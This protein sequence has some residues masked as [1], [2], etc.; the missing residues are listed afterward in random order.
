M[1][2]RILEAMDQPELAPRL[3][4]LT[5]D[6]LC[7]SLT[8]QMPVLAALRRP[9]R[10]RR[11]CPAALPRGRGTRAAASCRRSRARCS[12]TSTTTSA[13]RPI[14]SPR[15]SPSATSGCARPVPRH[16]REALEASF[17]LERARILA[18]ARELHPDASVEMADH[19]LTKEAN[20]EKN[21]RP[22][23]PSS[24]PSPDCARRS[25]SLQ[26]MP[27]ER[28]TDYQWEVLEAILQLLPYAAAH[29]KV[30]FGERGEADFT[31][32]AQGA[33]ARARHAAR[34]PTDLLLA[35][36]Y[37]IKHILVDEFQDT[38][39]S[40]WELL[41]LLTSGWTGDDGRTLFLVGDPMQS[42]YRFREAQV[43]LFLQARERGLGQREARAAHAHHQF[44]LAGR[45]S[46]TSS[47]RLSRESCPPRPTRPP[48]RFPTPARAAPEATRAARRG[49]DL[50]RAAGPRSRGAPCGASSCARPKDRRRDPRAQ[51]RRAR[52]HRARAQGRAASGFAPSRS[53]SSARSRWCRTSTP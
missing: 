23:P 2:K 24:S 39:I 21:A 25:I 34:H 31:E 8:R 28:Y 41:S 46:S 17:A 48:A 49:R 3:R 52:R 38:S 30:V 29:L 33:R 5:I 1:R 4:I 47:T 18:A 44:P 43:A 15:C 35:L 51:A 7:A 16:S 36:D 50:A 32:V 45:A 53:S 19:W 13:P 9:A 22:R 42:I 26:D 12:R 14:F 10:A 11:G 40:Q 37:R 20:L 6:A 27:P